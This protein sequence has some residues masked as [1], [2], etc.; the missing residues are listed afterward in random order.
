M[1]LA[2]KSR[3]GSAVR[4]EKDHCTMIVGNNPFEQEMGAGRKYSVMHDIC[5]IHLQ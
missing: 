3:E 2:T 5:M 4:A 1:K